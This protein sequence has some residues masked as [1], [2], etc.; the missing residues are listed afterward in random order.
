MLSASRQP[1]HT[2]TRPSSA[3]PRSI[4]LSLSLASW[5]HRMRLEMVRS[6]AM[7]FGR[8][9]SRPDET[10]QGDRKGARDQGRGKPYPTMDEDAKPYH[11]RGAPCGYQVLAKPLAEP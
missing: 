4:R 2:S 7:T 5:R 9:S 8:S 3:T 6:C 10:S 1:G 11:C